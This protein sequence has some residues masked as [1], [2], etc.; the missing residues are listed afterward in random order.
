MHAEQHTIV[1]CG[2]YHWYNS[3]DDGL[4]T[5]PEAQSAGLYLWAIP[6]Q[7]Q[8]LTYYV[9]ETG[10]SFIIRFAEHAR[11]YLSGIYRLYDPQLFVQGQKVLL[12]DGMWSPK[13]RH[14]MGAF[15]H[16]QPELAPHIHAFLGALKIFLAPMEG[17]K[18]VRQRLEAALAHHL[19]KQP[20]IVGT[21]QDSGLRYLPRRANEEPIV[22]TLVFPEPILGMPS[23]LLI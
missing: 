16:R 14:H 9:G 18:R 6:Y 11:E 10:R 21:F 5:Q 3:S 20:E 23:E 15:L 13:S 7:G 8:Y 1:W 2:P 12:W 4:F 22:C 19:Y 17:D